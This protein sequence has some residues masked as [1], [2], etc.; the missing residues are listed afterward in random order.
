MQLLQ[1]ALS[2]LRAVKPTFTD[3]A[4]LHLSLLLH[5]RL[6]HVDAAAALLHRGGLPHHLLLLLLLLLRHRDGRFYVGGYKETTKLSTLEGRW[7]TRD[8]S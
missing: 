4:G 2:L 8:S 1:K 3:S 6:L 7:V 5:P